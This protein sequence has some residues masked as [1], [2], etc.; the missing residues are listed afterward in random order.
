LGVFGI[1]DSLLENFKLLRGQAVLNILGRSDPV[2]G[3]DGR[4]ALLL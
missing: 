2:Q 3:P 4:L 1:L